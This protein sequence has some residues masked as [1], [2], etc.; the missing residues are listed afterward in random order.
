MILKNRVLKNTLEK[1]IDTARESIFCE[2]NE[3]RKPHF[4]VI[5]QMRMTNWND[6]DDFSVYMAFIKY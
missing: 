6:T 2:E 3:T 5:T 4:W 1:A